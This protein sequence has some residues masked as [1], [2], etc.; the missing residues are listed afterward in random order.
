MK[1][2][3]F[4]TWPPEG[5]MVHVYFESDDSIFW[6]E[7]CVWRGGCLRVLPQ[8]E[9]VVTHR[10]EFKNPT[11]LFWSKIVEPLAV[12]IRQARGLAPIPIVLDEEHR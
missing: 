1:W 11:P 2:S 9:F 10:E 12:R 4:E 6:V 8:A 3:T 7:K 5:A